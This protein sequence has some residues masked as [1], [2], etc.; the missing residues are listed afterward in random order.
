MNSKYFKLLETEINGLIKGLLPTDAQMNDP[1]YDDSNWQQ[2]I[3]SF[4]LLSHAAFEHYF[5]E[6][7]FSK[8]DEALN[9]YLNS[10]TITNILLSLILTYKINWYTEENAIDPP[11]GYQKIRSMFKKKYI[12]K[13]SSKNLCLATEKSIKDTLGEIKKL[14]LSEVIDKNLGCK[15]NNVSN[16]FLPLFSDASII[17]LNDTL[18]NNINSFGTV[19]GNYAHKCS[20]FFA[21]IPVGYMP[22]AT[23]ESAKVWREK[24]K[25]FIENPG[26]F[27]LKDFD[28]LIVSLK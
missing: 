27:C 15:K 12:G 26:V 22:T 8:C 17:K 18:F 25:L 10:G 4:I 1:A 6:L 20:V 28:E 5:E 14:Y 19:R 13:D 2:Q 9:E 23:V 21:S 16:L 3:K 7:A 24:I 11:K